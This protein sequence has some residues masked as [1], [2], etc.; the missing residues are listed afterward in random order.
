MKGIVDYSCLGYP[1][2]PLIIYTVGFRRLK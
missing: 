1:Y 2:S